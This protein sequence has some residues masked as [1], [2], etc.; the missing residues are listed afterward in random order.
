MVSCR[1]CNEKQPKHT[2]QRQRICRQCAR[3]ICFGFERALIFVSGPTFTFYSAQNCKLSL[4][5]KTMSMALLNARVVFNLMS[6]IITQI[7]RGS[8]PR[9]S[10]L[11]TPWSGWIPKANSQL[12]HA[13]FLY[14]FLF[15]QAGKWPDRKNIHSLISF[16]GE[17]KMN[18]FRYVICT[19]IVCF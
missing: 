10:H 8:V 2:W 7:G 6:P 16:L 4:K 14:E 13:C 15:L 11:R 3:D 5:V 12:P 9:F 18:Y 1:R 19:T 17:E